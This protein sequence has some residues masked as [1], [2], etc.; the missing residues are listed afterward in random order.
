MAK[1]RVASKESLLND[2][3]LAEDQYRLSIKGDSYSF[4]QA[5]KNLCAAR[6]KYYNYKEPGTAAELKEKID[7]AEIKYKE[8]FSGSSCSK[9]MDCYNELQRLRKSYFGV[10][11]VA[12]QKSIM[13]Q[14]CTG[15]IDDTEDDTSFNSDS[16]I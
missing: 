13:D 7:E 2:I 16:L 4:S 9:I 15:I 12:N 3:K 10:S 5:Y 11:G 6:E 8:S 14:Q 1:K